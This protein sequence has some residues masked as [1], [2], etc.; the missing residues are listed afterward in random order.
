[1]LRRSWNPW[2]LFKKRQRVYTCGPR[3]WMSTPCIRGYFVGGFVPEGS[4]T[5]KQRH[6]SRGA[7]QNDHDREL[8]VG[9]H[10]SHQYTLLSIEAL[11]ENSVKRFL[12]PSCKRIRSKGRRESVRHLQ[13]RMKATLSVNSTA[14]RSSCRAAWGRARLFNLLG[15]RYASS[16]GPYKF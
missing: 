10:N 1:M 6:R 16:L 8:I 9:G 13:C 3:Y 4:T 15:I 5:A 11:I 14:R 2:P 12:A 7:P